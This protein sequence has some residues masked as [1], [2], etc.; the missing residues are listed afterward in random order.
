L[1]PPSGKIVEELTST[2]ILQEVML[3]WGT[4]LLLRELCHLKKW[5]S[6]CESVMLKGVSL[7]LKPRN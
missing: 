3:L 1:W 7:L 4:V 2:I 6:Y 5:C